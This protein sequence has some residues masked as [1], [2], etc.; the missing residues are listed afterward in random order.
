MFASNTSLVTL[1]T[2]PSLLH[3]DIERV[4]KPNVDPLQQPRVEGELLFT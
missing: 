2:A 4:M 1:K 3:T